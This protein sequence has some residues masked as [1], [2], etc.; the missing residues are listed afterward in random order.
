MLVAHKDNPA[1]QM[2][3]FFPDPKVDMKTIENYSKNMEDG[4]ISR[5]IIVGKNG[6]TPTA[7]QV[8][9]SSILYM[10]RPTYKL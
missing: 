10:H 7:K 6:I 4:K 5:A 1:D 9:L 2:V 3:V 8:N